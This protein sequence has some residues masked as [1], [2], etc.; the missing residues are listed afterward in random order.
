MKA[1][2]FR[3]TQRLLTSSTFREQ[4]WRAARDMFTQNNPRLLDENVLSPAPERY[5]L[6]Q[7]GDTD[8]QASSTRPIFITARFRSG[9]TFLWQLFRA[10]PQVTCYYE[11]LNER[12][13][14]LLDKATHHV[15]QT[16]L[17][18][19]D[20]RREYEGMEDLN[21]I[22]KADWQERY[23][24]M[25]ARSHDPALQ[26]YISA[27]VKRAAGRPVLQF[28]RVDFRL[29]WLRAH[30]PQALIVHLY[31]D[32]REQ[33]M[34]MICKEGVRVPLDY[35]LQ[36][37]SQEYNPFYTLTWARDLRAIFPFLEPWGQ[38]PYA[39][40]YLLWRLSYSFGRRY[41][42]HGVCYEELVTNFHP[43]ATTL[44]E[45]VGWSQV[46]VAALAQLNRGAEK[47]RA[48]D[49][50][51]AEWYARI[52]QECE[53]ILTAYFSA[54]SFRPDRVDLNAGT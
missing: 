18:V 22:F 41:A 23:F 26:A 33:W 46:D 12:R 19:D 54:A 52:E 20:Y 30:F 10:V 1:W 48:Y 11:P 5:G 38:H 3:F 8:T 14:F 29:A 6:A 42:D 2:F 40:H 45:A 17:G 47:Q 15:D 13:W 43:T 28:N 34:S 39:L 50:A 35:R 37:G 27:L 51:S 53:Q 36:R 9:S 49:Y 7:R 4:L 24:Y 16:H 21:A 32:P 31:R 44:F 25:D